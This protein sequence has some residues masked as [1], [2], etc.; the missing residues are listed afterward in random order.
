MT[1]TAAAAALGV[2]PA[3]VRNGIKDGR[4]PGAY[5]IDTPRGP[6]WEIPASAV[7]AYRAGSRGQ[8]GPKRRIPPRLSPGQ[9]A[10][11]TGQ[12]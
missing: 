7:D 2:T 3:T 11:M 1:T 12:R 6:V 8:P 10:T 5:R 4:F 9:G